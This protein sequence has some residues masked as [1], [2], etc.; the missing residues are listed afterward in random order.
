MV[1]CIFEKYKNLN[2]MEIRLKLFELILFSVGL[3]MMG[4][5]IQ[6]FISGIHTTTTI[7]TFFLFFLSSL[8][9]IFRNRYQKKTIKDLD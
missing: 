5:N 7:I 3:L 1:K 2:K 9:I 8:K 4:V 6:A